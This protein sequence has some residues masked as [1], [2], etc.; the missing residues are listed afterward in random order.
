MKKM[1]FS[2]K[3]LSS[4]VSV[5]VLRLV[6]GGAML[7][8]GIPKFQKVMAGNFQFADPFGVGQEA[9]LILAVFAEVICSILLIIGLFTRVALIPLII[10]MAVAFFMIHGSDDFKIRELSLI[11]LCMYISIFFAGAGKIS[12]DEMIKK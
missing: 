2:N 1:F 5:L 6:A 11:Y 10:T 8:H 9:S 12:I 4:S 7:S 3:A